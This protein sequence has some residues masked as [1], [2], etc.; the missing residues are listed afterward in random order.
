MRNGNLTVDVYKL[1]LYPEDH[2]G[3]N[4]ARAMEATLDAWDLDE[5]NQVCSTTDSGT[6]I[7]KAAADLGWPRLSKMYQSSWTLSENSK[8][9]LH[10][11]EMQER[12]N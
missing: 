1:I 8:C 11:L 12:I 3:E 9:F 2:T 6:N 4:L 7:I 5:T 10:V